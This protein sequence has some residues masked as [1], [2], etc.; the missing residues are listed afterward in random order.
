MILRRPVFAA[1]STEGIRKDVQ[2]AP[3]NIGEINLALGPS[4]EKPHD[5]NTCKQENILTHLW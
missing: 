5:P 4:D 2:I 3:C 1:I